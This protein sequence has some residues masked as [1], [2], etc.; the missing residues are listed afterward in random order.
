VFLRNRRLPFHFRKTSPSFLP[1]RHYLR[2]KSQCRRRQRQFDHLRAGAV[3]TALGLECYETRRHGICRNAAALKSSNLSPRQHPVTRFGLCIRFH[4][5][6]RP[7]LE[8]E[9][10]HVQVTGECRSNIDNS[11]R[12]AC[13]KSRHQPSGQ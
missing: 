10:V 12:R 3:A 9:V 6:P 1:P 8:L 7:P 11:G 4:A 5:V 2:A 13:S